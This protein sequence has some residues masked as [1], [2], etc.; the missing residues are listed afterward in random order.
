[1]VLQKHNKLAED[2]GVERQLRG[3]QA[4][5]VNYYRAKARDER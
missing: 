5:D 3:L 2:D 4:V 1:M